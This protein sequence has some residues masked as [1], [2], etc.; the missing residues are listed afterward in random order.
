MTPVGRNGKML[1]CQVGDE[2]GISNAY[3]PEFKDVE[4]DASVVLFKAKA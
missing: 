3:I 1:R 2:T 4:V